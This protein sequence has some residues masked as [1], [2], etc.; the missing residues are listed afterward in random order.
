MNWKKLTAL[1]LALAIAR[2][3]QTNKNDWAGKNK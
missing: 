3:R 1:A 2:V